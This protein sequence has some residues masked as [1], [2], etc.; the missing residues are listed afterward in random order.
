M[1]LFIFQ[2]SRC[3]ISGVY[4]VFKGKRSST[5][6]FAAS[7]DVFRI[8]DLYN[9]FSERLI[10]HYV[11]VTLCHLTAPHCEYDN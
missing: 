3:F 6:L 11:D 9:I 8:A 7:F 10:R 2:I 5:Q 4:F 1:Q